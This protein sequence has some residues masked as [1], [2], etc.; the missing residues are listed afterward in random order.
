[1]AGIQKGWRRGETTFTHDNLF[2]PKKRSFIPYSCSNKENETSFALTLNS[3]M[4]EITCLLLMQGGGGIT[5][6]V[7]VFW[8]IL[9]WQIFF[10][11]FFHAFLSGFAVFRPS[12]TPPH[13]WYYHVVAEGNGNCSCCSCGRW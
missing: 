6:S 5:V 3:S 12:Y 1:M 9:I 13:K 11:F 4:R 7:I 2:P 8:Q 10:L